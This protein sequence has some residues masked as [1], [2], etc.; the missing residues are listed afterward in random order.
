PVRRRTRQARHFG[1]ED[2][3][4]TPVRDV[5]GE[6]LKAVAPVGALTASAEIVIDDLHS[7]ARPPERDRAALER[8]LPLRR[9]GVSHELSHRRL[10]EIDAG[11]PVQVLGLDLRFYTH[12]PP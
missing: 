10:T 6:A 9:F 3:A 11:A 2:R 5:V 1:G 7:L 12:R 4:H 8:V